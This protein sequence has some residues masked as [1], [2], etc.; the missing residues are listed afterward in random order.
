MVSNSQLQSALEETGTI[1]NDGEQISVR[2]GYS[3][4]FSRRSNTVTL[5]RNVEQ[6]IEEDLDERE[7]RNILLDILNYYVTRL[8]SG[9]S[10]HIKREFAEEFDSTAPAVAGFVYR[11]V[12]DLWLDAERTDEYQGLKKYHSA[13][14]DILAEAERQKDISVLRHDEQLLKGIRQLAL[15]GEVKGITETDESV[16]KFLAWTKTKLAEAQQ[17]ETSDDRKSIAAE[18]TEA[19]IAASENPKYLQRKLDSQDYKSFDFPSLKA[20]WQRKTGVT[21]VVSEVLVNLR[22]SVKSARQKTPIIGQIAAVAVFLGVLLYAMFPGAVSASIPSVEA[23]Q[24]TLMDVLTVIMTVMLIALAMYA[25]YKVLKALASRYEEVFDKIGEILSKYLP[26]WLLRLLSFPSGLFNSTKQMNKKA[27]KKAEQKKDPVQSELENPRYAERMEEI[28]CT[29]ISN[30]IFSDKSIERDDEEKAEAVVADAEG[31]EDVEITVASDEE[32]EAPDMVDGFE[33]SSRGDYQS[34]SYDSTQLRELRE[35]RDRGLGNSYN[36]ISEIEDE[37]KSRGLVKKLMQMFDTPP[38]LRE[39]TEL[40]GHRLDYH[41]VA[42]FFA[43]NKSLFDE[44][45]RNRQYLPGGNRIVGVAADFSGSVNEMDT[46][47][48]ITAIARAAQLQGDNFTAA[49]FSESAGGPID[50]DTRLITGPNEQ[51]ELEHNSVVF[52]SSGTPLA[53]G[54]DTTHR[55]LGT[56]NA[57]EQVMFVITDGKPNDRMYK[58][59]WPHDPTACAKKAIEIAKANNIA[60]IGFGVDD[61]AEDVMEELFGHDGYVMTDSDDLAEELLETYSAKCQSIRR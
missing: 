37:M 17:A 57:S 8:D 31:D 45:Y 21:K 35:H 15:T 19:L 40:H 9:D 58:D 4:G 44:L 26:D 39:R 18:I 24:D 55:L 32:Y 33:L 27:W 22:D 7:K 42:E 2:F 12:E 48:A 36:S 38:E 56:S 6:Y 11:T 41:N 25:V 20:R 60:V 1:Y 30:G 28:E 43:G 3:P 13:R 52:A 5:P 54:V 46:Q 23:T 14:T 49:G 61:V 51:F 59:D 50:S 34:H 53:N 47:I 10:E 16:Q 29:S